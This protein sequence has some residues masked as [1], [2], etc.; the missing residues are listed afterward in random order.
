MNNGS[1]KERVI[2]AEHVLDMMQRAN[3]TGDDCTVEIG[4]GI[5]LLRDLLAEL[6]EAT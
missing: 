5:I 6:K 3:E 1:N 4:A 2:E